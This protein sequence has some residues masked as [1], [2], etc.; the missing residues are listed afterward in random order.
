MPLG[1]QLFSCSRD[2]SIFLRGSSSVL[3]S[4][5]SF[6]GYVTYFGQRPGSYLTLPQ[7]ED[8]YLSNSI[9]ISFNPDES[10]GKSYLFS[11]SRWS[12]G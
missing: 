8:A 5:V 3:K 9:T 10:T 4:H 6:T 7:L 12:S 11:E 1:K 2:D